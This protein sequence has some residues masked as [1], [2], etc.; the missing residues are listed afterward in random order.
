MQISARLFIF[1]YQRVRRL[2]VYSI[3]FLGTKHFRGHFVF[4]I[5][6]SVCIYLIPVITSRPSS[7]PQGCREHT[8]RTFSERR[9]FLPVMPQRLSVGNIRRDVPRTRWG[10]NVRRLR[11]VRFNNPS[12]LKSLASHLFITSG[13]SVSLSLGFSQPT[14]LLELLP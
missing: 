13:F 10:G 9:V 7:S 4:A 2:P 3:L 5:Y 6:S 8:A 12:F 11:Q 14:K 1:V